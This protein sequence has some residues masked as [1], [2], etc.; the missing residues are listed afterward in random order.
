MK[1]LTDPW[2]LLR[3]E[4]PGMGPGDLAVPYARSLGATPYVWVGLNAVEIAAVELLVPWAWLAH[5]LTVLGVAGLWFMFGMYS[6]YVVRP[7][8]LTGDRLLLRAGA[9]GE[10]EIPRAL[11]ASASRRQS[12][13]DGYF[14]RALDDRL[15]VTV[16]SSA[17]VEVRLTEPYEVALPKGGRATVTAVLFQAD[18]PAAV[19]EALRDPAVTR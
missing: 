8:V 7:H 19:I 6:G 18:D 15:A 4:R 3:R 2:H 17:N 12:F 14:V 1:F 16:D 11:I 5:A 13:P 9:W 10:V